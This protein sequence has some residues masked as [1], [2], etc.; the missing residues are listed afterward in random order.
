[1]LPHVLIS[2]AEPGT[3]EE[4]A[5]IC[6]AAGLEAIETSAPFEA[7]EQAGGARPDLV[8]VD[9]GEGGEG[10]TNVLEDLGGGPDAPPVIALSAP[11]DVGA[12]VRAMR[13]GAADVLEKPVA[14]EALEGAMARLLRERRAAGPGQAPLPRSE[15]IVG[16]SPAL[17][18]VLEHIDR[19]A[20]APRSTVLITGESGVG[21]ELVARAVHERSERANGPF[22]ALNCAAL[23]EGLLEAE[24]FGYEPGAFTGGH[25]KGREGLFAAAAG[26]SLL[27]D[28]V[29]ELDIQVQAKLLRVLQERCFRRV[30]GNV[31][32]ESDVRI[33]ASTNRDLVAMVEAGT[34]REDLYYRL[35]VLS[36]TVPPL[37]ERREDI[38]L[39]AEHRL[40][41]LGRELGRPFSGFS[42]SA[43]SLLAAHPWSGNVR[44]LE[45]AVERAA[46]L[47]PGGAIRP[48]HL[49]LAPGPVLAAST[50]PAPDTWNLK[51]AE[52]R[53]IRHVL[54]QCSGNRSRTAR[55]LGINR[56]TLYNKL[57][58]YG[59]DG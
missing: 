55:E 21:K 51:R 37:R 56:T 25:P 7:L 52:E 24:L 18:R 15:A 41:Q 20:A 42:D 14:F 30:G 23:A 19:V 10:A 32:F 53:L 29:G 54:T 36:I 58:L 46:I 13:A 48:E 9:L 44:E 43:L 59:I 34:F 40:E 27:L 4:L 33:I 6:R 2:S 8:L 12:A 26:G 3:R 17:R 31:D 47:A 45:N 28:E 22:V 11:S 38:P 16:R 39:L 1:M 49:G 50:T 57:R 35:N 5:R